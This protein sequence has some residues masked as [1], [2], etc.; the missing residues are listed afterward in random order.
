M[1]K[2]LVDVICNH[3]CREK[4]NYTNQG[5]NNKKATPWDGKTLERN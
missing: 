1:A 4:V 3:G 5:K 2:N